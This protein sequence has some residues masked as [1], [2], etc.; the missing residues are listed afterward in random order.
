[1]LLLTRGAPGAG[2]STFIEQKGLAPYTLS[3]DTL[4]LLHHSPQLSEQ[5]SRSISHKSEKK[6]WALLL[7]L[8]EQRMRQGDLTVVDATHTR[9]QDYTKYKELALRYRYRVVCIDFSEVPKETLL[10]HNQKRL[11]FKIVA[12]EV[13]DKFHHRVHASPIPSWIKSVKPED[14]DAFFRYE[15]RDLSHYQKVHHIGDVHGCL[16]PLSEFLS[17]GIQEDEFYIFVGDYIDRGL[18]NAETLSFLFTLMDRKNVVF[19]E[20]NHEIHLWNW[21]NGRTAA[22]KEFEKNTRPELE[23]SQV[24]KKTARTFYRALHQCFLYTYGDK[25]VLVT[26]GGLP[27]IPENMLTVPTEQLIK[28]VGDYST[29]IDLLFDAETSAA[30]YQIHGHRNIQRHPSQVTERTFNLEGRIEKGE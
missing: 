24:S 7:S 4:R 30:E 22:S 2:K 16:T 8:L 26:H 15:P 18:Q 3:P 19:L 12:E 14:F 25:R 9:A 28:G 1:M 27:Y 13:I 10:L 11:D 17:S 6:V 23:H 5:G 29:E 21:A 20:G